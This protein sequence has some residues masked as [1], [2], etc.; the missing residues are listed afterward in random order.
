MNSDFFDWD[1]ANISHIAE[2]D[3]SPEEAEQ[4]LLGDSLEI[5]FDVANGEERWT[6]IGETNVARIL[7]VVFTTRN[8]HMRVIT[9][10]SP[11]PLRMRIYLEWRAQ[12][13]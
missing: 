8:E 6:Y 3:V 1:D 13:S 7:T 9:A 12:Q 4:V 2:H 11:S 10:F 5:D